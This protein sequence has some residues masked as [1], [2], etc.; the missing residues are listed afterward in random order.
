MGERFGSRVW[1]WIAA[2]VALLAVASMGFGPV[3]PAQASTRASRFLTLLNS[4]TVDNRWHGG[5]SRS[6]FTLWIDA[7]GDGCN[8]RAEVLL[9]DSRVQATTNSYCTVKQGY[10][11]SAYDGQVFTQGHFLDIDHVVPLAEAWRSGAYGWNHAR[12]QAFANDLGYR[13]SLQEVSAASNRSKSD[14]DPDHWMPP[15][16]SYA[17]NY[18]AQWV[19]IKW[20]W[21][22]RVDSVE[23][24]FLRTLLATCSSVSIT[25]PTRA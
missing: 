15:L 9:R 25:L 10:W 13:Y 23:R 16:H 8:T 18:A 2:C 11:V 12:R 22:L 1:R 3:S 21:R 4:L 7:N 5:Y 14:S 17:C 6:L 19:G 24:A 20:R